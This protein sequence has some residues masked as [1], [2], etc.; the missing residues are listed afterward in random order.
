MTLRPVKLHRL[1][2]LAGLLASPGCDSEEGTENVAAFEMDEL[3][4]RTKTQEMLRRLDSAEFAAKVRSDEFL[5]KAFILVNNRRP[6]ALEFHVLKGVVEEGNLSRSD[7]LTMMLADRRG[8]ITEQ[9]AR[10]LLA[11]GVYE[12]LAGAR[13]V[14]ALAASL[15]RIPLREAMATHKDQVSTGTTGKRALAL[16]AAVPDE[17]YNTYFGYLHSHTGYSDGQGTP[18]QAYRHA[19][20]QGGMDFFAVSDHSELLSTW[21]FNNEWAKIRSAADAHY[22]PGSYVTLWGFEYSNPLLGHALVLNTSDFTS[23][24]TSLL[25]GDLYGWIRRRPAGF[26]TFNHPG[27]YDDLGTEFYHLAVIDE[28]VVPQV[29]G[30]ELWNGADG[31]DRFYYDNQWNDSEV[32][33]LDIGNRNGWFLGALGGQDNHVPDWGTKNQFRTAVL[34]KGLTREELIEA[35]RARRFYATEDK[36]LHLDVRCAGF[37]MGSRLAGVPR[38]FVVSARDASGDAFSELRL[39]RD[40]VLV[41]VS[42]VAGSDVSTTFTDDGVSRGAYYYVIVRQTDDNDGNGRNDEAISSPIWID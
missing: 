7:V 22:Q 11:R 32:S 1:V 28:G 29:L 42:A 2:L 16:A 19:R 20:D 24:F 13:D 14:R 33:Y 34:A 37:P 8:D 18:D 15:K 39:Y 21:W 31:F 3:E 41:D 38:R 10:E 40:G 6:D 4:V 27:N 26:A 12:E 36:D 35:Y 30:I 25:L 5:V 9:M 17:T 23:A